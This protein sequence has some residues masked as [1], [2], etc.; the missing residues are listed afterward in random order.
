MEP[1]KD[2][3][4]S[5]KEELAKRMRSSFFGAFVIAWCVVNYE[6]L[7]VVF[8]EGNYAERI[9]YIARHLSYGSN[10]LHNF[11]W[12]LVLASVSTFALPV[13]NLITN[14]WNRVVDILDTQMNLWMETKRRVSDPEL[15]NLAQVRKSQLD[16]LRQYARVRVTRNGGALAR[17]FEHGHIDESWD[18]RSL[19]NL[20]KASTALPLEHVR[21]LEKVGFPAQGYRMLQLLNEEGALSEERLLR[22]TKES[23]RDVPGAEILGTLLGLGLVNIV[24]YEGID[25]L[26]EISRTGSGFFNAIGVSYPG[27]FMPRTM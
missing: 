4:E 11:G 9:G 25:P 24:W 23:G 21:T 8:S 18:L 13:V 6:F 1:L 3:V 16:A 14:S 20:S 22:D 10:L 5:V 19:D 26:Y 12:P 27:I 17:L 15:R 7:I 2:G